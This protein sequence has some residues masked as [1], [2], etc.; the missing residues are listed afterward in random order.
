MNIVHALIQLGYEN[1]TDFRVDFDEQLVEFVITE[2]H[3]NTPIPSPEELDA[4][5][6][7]WLTEN[8]TPLSDLKVVAKIN[9]DRAAEQARLRYVTTGSGQAMTYREKADDAASYVAAGYPVDMTAYPFILAESNATGKTGK[10]AADDIIAKRELWVTIGSRIE[11]KR[12]GG[13][14]NV[15]AA[16][17]ESGVDSARD[18]AVILLDAI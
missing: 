17:D 13:K 10:Q 4:A 7:E 9:I 16:T 8:A 2:W 1:Q 12:V 6:A 3:S 5:W 14:V 15:D 18:Q 11:E